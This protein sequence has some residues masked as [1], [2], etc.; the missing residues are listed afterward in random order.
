MRHT[1]EHFAQCAIAA[2]LDVALPPEALFFA[3]PNGGYRAKA[4]AAKLKAE[5]VK[6]G[7]AD[8]IVVVKDDLG[9]N[10]I[11]L[12]T[13]AGKGRTSKAQETFCDRLE[14][15]GGSYYV[16]RT[17]EDVAA[18]LHNAGVRLRVIPSTTPGRLYQ[19]PE[20]DVT[21]TAHETRRAAAILEAERMKR[22]GKSA[23]EIRR[24]LRERHGLTLSRS[25]VIGILFRLKDQRDADARDLK[26]LA[27]LDA[28]AAPEALAA[29]FNVSPVYVNRLAMECPSQ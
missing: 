4:V 17:I 27:E 29:R 18:A 6:A 28:G 8:I 25:A 19:K 21:D 10:V 24:A 22:A 7:V 20:S 15:L 23:S 9:L 14:S 3:V 16:V 12:E 13:K 5:G 11:G 26:I 1:P 2:Y